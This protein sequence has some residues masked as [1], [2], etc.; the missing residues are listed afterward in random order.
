MIF[1]RI[2][3]AIEEN[4]VLAGQSWTFPEQSKDSWIMQTSPSIRIKNPLKMI[5]KRRLANLPFCFLNLYE[6]V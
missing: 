5:K 4:T 3:L 1:I 6:A 2:P